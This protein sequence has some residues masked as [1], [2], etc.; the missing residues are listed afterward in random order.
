MRLV[1]FNLSI[2]ELDPQLQ[3]YFVKD[4]HDLP[5]NSLK[6]SE[7]WLIMV[8]GKKP[9][10]L[11][12]FESRTQNINGATQLGFLDQI[13]HKLFGYHLRNDKLILG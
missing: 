1:D 3:L 10:T 5:V 2:A 11:N 9:L 13:P 7:H 4:N 6:I 12:Q 8:S